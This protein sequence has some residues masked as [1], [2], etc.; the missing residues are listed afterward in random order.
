MMTQARLFALVLVCSA[1]NAAHADPAGEAL[2]KSL[3]DRIDKQDAWSASAARVY[4]EGSATV[5]EGLKIAM[6]D[7]LASFAAAKVRLDKLAETPQHSI[8]IGNFAASDLALSGERWSITVP[9]A[10]G[11]EITTADISDWH[12]DAKAPFTS[13]ARLYTALAKAE[14]DEVAIPKAV[15]SQEIGLFGS[16]TKT[17]ASYSDF[18]LEGLKKGVLANERI[19]HIESVTSSP[20]NEPVTTLSDAMSAKNL[21]IGAFAHVFDPADYQSGKGDGLWVAGLESGGYGKL[22]V[23]TGERNVFVAGQIST[24]QWEVR[25]TPVPMAPRFDELFA[26]GYPDEA[27]LGKFMAEQIAALI[28][29]IKIG[30]ITVKDVAAFPPEGGSISLASTAIE[31]LS[32]ESMKHL[33]LDGFGID[34]SE[35]ILKCDKFELGQVIW[36]SVSSIV[37][38]AKLGEVKKQGALP[39]PA[40]VDEATDALMNV[41]PHIGKF[42]ISG[43]QAGAPGGEPFKLSE[44]AATTEAGTDLLPKSAT[45]T[46]RAMTIPRGILRA[47]PETAQIFDSLGYSELVVDSEG[48]ATHDEASGRYSGHGRLSVKDAGTLSISH[49]TGGLTAERMKALTALLALPASGTPDTTQMLAAAGP[50]SI[51]GF[52][53]RFEDASLTRRVLPFVAKMQGMDEAMLIGNVTAALQLGLAALGNQTFTSEVVNSVATFLKD[54]KSL[55]LALRPARPVTIQELM[56][57][58]PSK[59]GAVIDLLGIHVTANN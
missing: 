18:H 28:G 29:W 27:K 39:D 34:S 24:G 41:V 38:L 9:A 44:Y 25:Q 52:T 37:V 42:S 54:P 19:G 36:P 15:L 51:E 53:V 8:A 7:G 48:E 6:T 12:F 31:D 43:V 26:S 5:V 2:V 30:V 20:D 56:A 22:T 13:A 59:P 58:D 1:A 57:L 33:V 14:F 40:L 45:S 50:V 55:S 17:V 35:L 10:T 32:A 49:A 11:R 21:N 46:V 23:K 16:T 47:T 4:S 3:I